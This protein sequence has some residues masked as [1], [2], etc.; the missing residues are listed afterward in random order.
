MV[1]P[2]PLC[3][4]VLAAAAGCATTSAMSP[5]SQRPEAEV[6]VLVNSETSLDL[7]DDEE[8]VHVRSQ[9]GARYKV[10]PGRHRLGVSLSIINVGPD[11][12]DDNIERSAMTAIFCID[13][14]AG[15][16]YVIGHEGRGARW[17]PQ[18]TVDG[19]R[20]IV[21]FVSCAPP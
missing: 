9:D 11:A 19:T 6:A 18:V 10:G 4:A 5:G 21:P 13:V 8:L 20:A 12:A 3:L 1:R 14:Q 16:A 17:R 2:L 7:L 15:H